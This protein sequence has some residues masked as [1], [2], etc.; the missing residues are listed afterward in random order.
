VEVAG[1]VQ[2]MELIDLI[3]AVAGRVALSLENA[4]L[5]EQ[6]QTLAQRELTVNAISAR[7]QTAIGVDELLR[8]TLAELGRTLGATS[9]SIRIGTKQSE[10]IQTEPPVPGLVDGGN[11]REH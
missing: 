6:A 1:G 5:F 3:K 10:P 4:R 2:Q 7:M 8:T 11:G 9:G